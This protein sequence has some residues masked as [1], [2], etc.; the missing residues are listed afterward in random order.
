MVLS[1]VKG[2]GHAC[3]CYLCAAN[4]LSLLLDTNEDLTISQIEQ[5]HN[6]RDCNIEGAGK[7][8]ENGD[9]A[10]FRLCSHLGFTPPPSGYD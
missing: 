9:W 6:N 8:Q 5:A 10:P 4:L 7:K 1:F 2:I 3:T